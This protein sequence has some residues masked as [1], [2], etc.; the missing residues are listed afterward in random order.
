MM[1]DTSSSAIVSQFTSK[2]VIEATKCTNS[3]NKG[4]DCFDGNLMR[5]HKLL[6]EKII[7]E[8]T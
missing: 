3:F 2:E 7:N 8:I 1:I 6:E 5:N 4:M